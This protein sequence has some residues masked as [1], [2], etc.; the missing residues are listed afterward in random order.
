MS[1]NETV[2]AYDKGREQGREETFNEGWNEAL[3]LVQKHLGRYD[4]T[5]ALYDRMYADFEK[6][7]K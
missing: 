4:M 7:K 6:K 2:A 3:E 1:I 5:G